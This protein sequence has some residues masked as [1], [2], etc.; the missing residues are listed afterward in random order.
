MAVQPIRGRETRSKYDSS[1]YFVY[2]EG[3]DITFP[4]SKMQSVVGVAEMNSTNP[5]IFL[6]K[7]LLGSNVLC[8]MTTPCVDVDRWWTILSNK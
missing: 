1:T 2:M 4:D 8:V 6:H 3:L 5:V 7:Q